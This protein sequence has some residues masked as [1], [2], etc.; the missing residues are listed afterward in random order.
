MNDCATQRR[1]RV[2]VLTLGC[3]VNQY[4]SARIADELWRQGLDV[5]S[6]QEPLDVCVINT[7]SVTHVA[8]AKSRQAIRRMKRRNPQMLLVVTGCG[9]AADGSAVAGLGEIDLLVAN[10]EKDAAAERVLELLGRHDGYALPAPRAA[11]CALPPGGRTRALLKVQDGC[12]HFCS[13]C[14]IPY[15][16]GR[17]RSRS[18]AEVLEEARAIAAAGHREVVVTGICVGAYADQGRGLPD[19]LLALAQIAGIERVRLSSIEPTDVTDRLVDAFARQPKLCRHLHI[20][21]QSG[22]DAVLRAMNRTYTAGQYVGMVAELRAALPGVAITTDLLV[23]FPGETEDQFRSTM[24]VAERCAFSRLHVFP[25]SPRDGT[26][27][28]SMPAQVPAEEKDRRVR[29]L[30]ALGGHLARRFAEAHVGREVD[31]LVEGART[32]PGW[33]DGL[34]DT[35][36]RVRFP[37]Q[38]PLRGQIA[39]VRVTGV[40]D[41][42]AVGEEVPA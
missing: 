31:V 9:T 41:D 38:R 2:G 35:Y 1:P 19:L 12:S 28:A 33:A 11:S 36:L 14:I 40:A 3:K 21:L 7:C 4:E 29:E 26:P 18:F 8:A 10:H 15:T 13:Y 16:R 24:A 6:W 34:T 23:G 20:P 39:T 32:E 17:P 5:V 22:D 30:V 37:T 42:G 27:A 25:F